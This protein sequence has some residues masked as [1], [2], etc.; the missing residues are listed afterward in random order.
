MHGNKP[1]IGADTIEPCDL[2]RHGLLGIESVFPLVDGIAVD[3]RNNAVLAT[4]I[5]R[6]LE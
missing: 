1:R 3:V 6:L 5:T 4:L 2:A